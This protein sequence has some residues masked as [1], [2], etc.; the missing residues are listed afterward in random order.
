MEVA[1]QQARAFPQ[2][3]QAM[4]AGGEVSG[5]A[6]GPLLTVTCRAS[7]LAL[8]VTATGAPGRAC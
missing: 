8:T 1:S 6:G 3:R 2:A 7:P 4:A 5:V